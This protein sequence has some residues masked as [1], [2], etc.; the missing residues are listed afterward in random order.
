MLSPAAR[1]C[2][3]KQG[4]YLCFEEDALETVVLRITSTS[5]LGVQPEMLSGAADRVGKGPTCAGAAYAP[6]CRDTNIGPSWLDVL[7]GQFDRFAL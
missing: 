1:K 7:D 6:P 5:P 2:G 3:F 4:G